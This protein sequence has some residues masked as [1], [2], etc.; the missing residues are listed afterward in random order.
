MTECDRTERFDDLILDE[1]DTLSFNFTD[2]LRSGQTVVNPAVVATVLDG[3]DPNP[4]NI[5]QGSPG[6]DV[7]LKIASINIKGLVSDVT[8]CLTMSV[9]TTGG[10]HLKITGSLTVK[11]PCAA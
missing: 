4:Q 2:I 11:L 3:T 1:T 7:T 6:V 9:N 8:Y 5:V 10:L